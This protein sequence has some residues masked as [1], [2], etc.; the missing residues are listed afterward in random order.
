VKLNELDNYTFPE[1]N[2]QIIEVLKDMINSKWLL[3]S[4]SDYA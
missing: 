1:A 2:Q 4:S 3:L